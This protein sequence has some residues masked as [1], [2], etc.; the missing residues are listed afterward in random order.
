MLTIRGISESDVTII[1]E[2]HARSWQAS[3]RG[4]LHDDY[5]D[6]P[7]F[8]ERFTVWRERLSNPDPEYLGLIAL[9]DASVVGFAF[10]FEAHHDRWGTMLD[11]LHVAP[12][13]RGQCI[14]TRLLAA[15][16]DELLRRRTA[17]GIYLWVFE[18]NHRARRYY[19]R[20][21][22]EAVER[23]VIDAPGGGTVAEWLYA[24]GTIGELNAAI[25]AQSRV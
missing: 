7:I 13:V 20:L 16:A 5:L 12:E 8:E 19:E 21:G 22:A 11:N 14:G 1:A 23:C 3:Y 17:G 18:A 6:G 2:L 10:A 15:L 9:S 24:W 4:I 25:A